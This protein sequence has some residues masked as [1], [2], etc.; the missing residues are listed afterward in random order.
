ML[1]QEPWCY[2]PDQIGRLTDWQILNL[3]AKPAI[4]RSKQYST[5]PSPGAAAPA[6]RT[7]PHGEGAPSSGPPGEPGSPQHRSACIGAYMDVQGL[8][9]ERAVAQYEKQLDQ[10]REMQKKGDAP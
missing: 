10:W 8:S 1:S 3:Y 9:R 7:R 4:E 6:G 5:T 2:T